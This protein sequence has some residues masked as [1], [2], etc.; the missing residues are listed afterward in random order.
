MTRF[1]N[2]YTASSGG[3]RS[4]NLRVGSPGTMG[5]QPGR[6]A[7]SFPGARSR[8]APS[9]GGIRPV[10][11]GRSGIPRTSSGPLGGAAA[12][13]AARR[14]LGRLGGP[15]GAAAYYLVKFLY[16]QYFLDETYG[17]I[18]DGPADYYPSA[19][20]G[21]VQICVSTP[22]AAEIQRKIGSN[23]NV[24]PAV[25]V[26]ACNVSTVN[27]ANAPYGADVPAGSTDFQ[28]VC[29][30]AAWPNRNGRV[31]ERWARPG[32]STAPIVFGPATKTLPMAMALPDLEPHTE[33]QPNPGGAA[34]G[35][36]IPGY[37]GG[38]EF[39]PGG[40]RPAPPHVP[41]PPRPGEREIKAQVPW[42]AGLAAKGFHTLTEIMDAAD[43]LFNALP[44]KTR[45]RYPGGLHNKVRAIAE[46]SDQIDWGSA[47]QCL[48]ANQV[49]DAI[50]GGLAGRAGRAYTRATG[51]RRPAPL[52]PRGL[53]PIRT[54]T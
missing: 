16:D 26:V 40:P 23:P 52:N 19:A 8:A 43:C 9:T 21:W 1:R 45:R 35:P 29:S 46:N 15:Y 44:G 20:D 11:R 48:V 2:A 39:G 36:Y 41:R 30:G 54:R 4:R 27:T 6:R 28:K 42:P 7:S 10:L 14:A 50:V 38:V 18:D 13:A 5:F 37:N 12:G 33:L 25:S 49:E 24:L 47:I 3:G 34:S 31:F 51:G 22:P 17:L 32:G 53:G